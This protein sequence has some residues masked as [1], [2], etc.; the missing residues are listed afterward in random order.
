[1]DKKVQLNLKFYK[2]TS[3]I[4]EVAMVARPCPLKQAPK[5]DIFTID[6]YLVSK[7]H[8]L[9]LNYKI[10]STIWKIVVHYL[11]WFFCKNSR[12]FSIRFHILSRF[13]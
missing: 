13:K 3:T 6:P 7:L 11:T 12:D 10:G 2:S 5:K 9:Q 4:L 8:V 1:M